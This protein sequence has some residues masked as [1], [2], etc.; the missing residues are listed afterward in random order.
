MPGEVREAAVIEQRFHVGDAVEVLD[1]GKSGHVRTPHYVRHRR[2]EILQF[3]GYF[4]NPEQ[5]SVGD[6]SGPLVPLYRVRF[7]MK[8]L[9][10]GEV[11]SGDDMLCIEIY[12][13]W[14]SPAPRD[15][16]SKE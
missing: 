7:R 13:H 14:L 12:D 11:R 10:P 15:T 8:D 4:L 16:L 9:W 2:G 3:C 6:V 1:L 5:L